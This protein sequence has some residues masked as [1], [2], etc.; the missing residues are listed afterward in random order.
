MEELRIDREDRDGLK[1]NNENGLKGRLKTR[2]QT[3]SSSH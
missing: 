3:A 2:F 1:K